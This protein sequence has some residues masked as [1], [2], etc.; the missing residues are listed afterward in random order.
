MK[1][2][3]LK[4]FALVLGVGLLVIF[5]GKV[6][7][8]KTYNMH[9]EVISLRFVSAISGNDS[10]LSKNRWIWI[11][12][13]L[14]ITKRLQSVDLA[15][16]ILNELNVSEDSSLFVK[17]KLKIQYTG[18]DENLW[19]I[20]VFYTDQDLA[21]KIGQSYLK[22]I[23]LMLQEKLPKNERGQSIPGQSEVIFPPTITGDVYQQKTKT[24][25]FLVVLLAFVASVSPLVFRKARN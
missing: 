3:S 22:K 5:M 6:L 20:D 21:I 8:P 25:I 1:D 2:I 16:S 14:E 4:F 17:N 10:E 7:I 18:G 23:E 12:D 15:K 9:A 11:R 24:M 13:G 19:I